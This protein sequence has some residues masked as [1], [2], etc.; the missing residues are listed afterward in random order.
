MNK[1]LIETCESLRG[2]RHFIVKYQLKIM[3]G[4]EADNASS[5]RASSRSRMPNSLQDQEGVVREKLNVLK[6]SA[7]GYV[8]TMSK[9]CAR[10]DDLL[11][12]FAN[13]VQVRNS[14]KNEM[15]TSD[16]T[17]NIQVI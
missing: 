13:L 10:I 6:R 5:I 15:F 1:L 2:P 11:A 12:D 14:A 9:V 8:A 3:D 7:G 17:V 4:I 16:I